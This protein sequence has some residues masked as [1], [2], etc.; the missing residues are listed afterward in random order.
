MSLIGF[1]ALVSAQPAPDSLFSYMEIAAKNNPAVLQKFY[2]YQ[3]ALQKV[4]QVGALPDPQL[5]LGVFISPMEL[6]E[7]R[8]VADMRLMQ[9]FPWF[10]TLRTAKDEMSLMAQARYE[11]FDNEKL[12]VFY[13]VQETWYELLKNQEE[14]HNTMANLEILRTVNRIATANYTSAAAGSTDLAGLYRIQIEIKDLENSDS[15]LNNERRTLIA[16][17]NSLLN[18]PAEMLVYLADTL[19][20]VTLNLPAIQ[21]SDSVFTQNPMVSM[22]QY[23]SQSLDAR[24]KMVTKMGLPMIGLGVD[25]SFI[26]TSSMST[27]SMN[28]KD[29]IMPMLTMTLPIYRQKYKAMQSE[30]DLLKTATEQGYNAAIND[31]RTEYY[32]NYQAMQDA[33]R[34]ITL[35]SDQKVLANKTLDIMLKS[36]SVNGTGLTEILQIEQQILDY[37]IRQSEA[38][39]EYNIAV[40]GLNKI[41]ATSQVP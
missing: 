5:S 1:S 35:Y 8:Q 30:A 38:V 9:M 32:E 2:E 4:P 33:Q 3:A 39:A 29:M 37:S 17:F 12:L 28:G 18:R 27:S 40:A 19:M 21:L 23:E 13:Q 20:P 7:G 14:T 24:K 16:R 34:R 22:L 10:G 25:Y 41:L 6:V 26:Q 11:E 36:F 31:L 15:T